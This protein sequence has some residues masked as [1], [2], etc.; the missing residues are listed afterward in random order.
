MAWKEPKTDWIAQDALQY[1]DYNRIKNN[2]EYLH[3]EATEMW[4]DFDIEDMGADMESNKEGWNYRYFN[5][6]E[7]NV[8]IINSHMTFSENYGFRQTFYS[9]GP[10]IGAT[11]L[12]RI[13]GAILGMNRI[14]EGIKAGRI[15]IAFRLGFPKGLYL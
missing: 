10:F 6:I 3:R 13:E 1:K 12:N 2:L 8:D 11:E 5:A 9:N 14:I 15:R 7:A 4:G